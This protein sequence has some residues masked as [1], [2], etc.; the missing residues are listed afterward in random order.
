MYSLKILPDYYEYSYHTISDTL[1]IKHG[2]VYNTKRWIDEEYASLVEISIP[3][4]NI[5]PE[6]KFKL[7]DSTIK[8]NYNWISIWEGFLPDHDDS[9][10]L[11][12]FVE[13]MAADTNSIMLKENI[14]VINYHRSVL[15]PTRKLKFKS[16]RMYNLKQ[17][18]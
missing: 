2:I 12:G 11:S 3:V 17:E 13:I 18:L 10:Q 6:N 4:E 8:I 1:E 5:N 7:G 9:I 15:S 14:K 16:R